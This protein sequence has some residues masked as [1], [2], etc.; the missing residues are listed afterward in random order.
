LPYAHSPTL[1][2]G[3]N[4]SE[5]LVIQLAIS[6]SLGEGVVAVDNHEEE[7]L[8]LSTFRDVLQTILE[9]SYPDGCPEFKDVAVAWSWVQAFDSTGLCRPPFRLSWDI[10]LKEVTIPMNGLKACI[11]AWRFG[12]FDLAVSL[13]RCTHGLD[14]YTRNKVMDAVPGILDL[15]HAFM[16]METQR[17]QGKDLLQS[18]LPSDIFCTSCQSMEA[19][20]QQSRYRI[21]IE[22]FL[23]QP[24]PRVGDFFEAQQWLDAGFVQ[25]C[26]TG[27]CRTVIE[28]YDFTLGQVMDIRAAVRTIPEEIT[29]SGEG[30]N[31]DK[32]RL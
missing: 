2:E 25:D 27:E 24:F 16:E 23:D 21:V 22:Y 29:R 17:E 12:Q 20:A 4:A 8:P 10:S 1:S 5:T 18:Y 19:H 9:S 11:L 14:V 6:S 31:P 7:V 28:G 13:S 26:R 32:D 15:R 3:P 30:G